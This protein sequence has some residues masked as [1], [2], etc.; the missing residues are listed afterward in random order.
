MVIAHR[1]SVICHTFVG[2]IALFVHGWHLQLLFSPIVD[3]K[4]SICTID[5]SGVN[6]STVRQFN[7]ARRKLID[8]SVYTERRRQQVRKFL[9]QKQMSS[10]VGSRTSNTTNINK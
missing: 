8:A 5:V 10:Y 3:Y 6:L 2:R 9:H 7:L 4:D 1:A